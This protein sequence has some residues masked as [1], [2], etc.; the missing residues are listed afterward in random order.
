MTLPQHGRAAD[1]PVLG[2]DVGGTAIK[3]HLRHPTGVGE[4]LAGLL[5]PQGDP[6]GAAVA[7]A[8]A[9]LVRLAGPVAAV[10]VAVPGVVDEVAGVCRSAVNLGWRDLAIR[11]LVADRVP[12]PVVLA[13]D[14]RAGARGE[15]A[16]GAGAGREGSL[17]FA[18]LG[19]GLGLAALDPDGVP[20]GGPW[21]GEVG[22]LRFGPGPHAG[23]RIEQ[24][25]S[26]GGFAQRSGAPDGLTAI[27]AVR[28]GDPRALALWTET[29][30]A[31]AELLAWAVAL[32]APDTI[33]LGGGLA[34][35]GDLL[36]D[37][38]RSALAARLQ[39]FPM[40]VVLP[41]V[42]GAGAAAV[43]AAELAAL[44]LRAPA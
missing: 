1:A 19:T 44:R 23:L 21:A 14:V 41:A 33:V 43:G 40:P 6:S 10:G 15:K 35:A 37:P 32:L 2:I 12:V 17:L 9:A 18:P 4:D 29:T 42:H 22:Q 31:L 16:T 27:A 13:Q 28:A 20:I 34:R 26:A 36:L 11:D 7:D 5:T 24:V 38:V 30:D 39:G 8:V 3:V 25:V